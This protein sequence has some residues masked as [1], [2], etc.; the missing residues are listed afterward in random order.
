MCVF[1]HFKRQGTESINELSELDNLLYCTWNWLKISRIIF[2]TK[3]IRFYSKSIF[4]I[5][6]YWLQHIRCQGKSKHCIWVSQAGKFH[7]RPSPQTLGAG[8][9]SALLPAATV[10]R[11]TAAAPRYWTFSSARV[12]AAPCASS[13]ILHIFYFVKILLLLFTVVI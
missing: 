11:C 9:A 12:D 5:W 4:S 3:K 6:R 2:S 13:Q 7:F 1:K 10:P 8:S